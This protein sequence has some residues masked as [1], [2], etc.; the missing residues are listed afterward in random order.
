M[1]VSQFSWLN[2]KLMFLST[3]YPTLLSFEKFW[4]IFAELKSKAQ[5]SFDANDNNKVQDIM[6]VIL[7][8][9][10]CDDLA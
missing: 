6:Y 10:S 7:H 9:F 1:L 2:N 8:S 5:R 4:T 3:F